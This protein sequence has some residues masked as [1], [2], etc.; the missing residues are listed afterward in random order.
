MNQ[1]NILKTG[2]GTGV[3][4]ALAAL[5]SVQLAGQA[6]ASCSFFGTSCSDL[7]VQSITPSVTNPVVGQPIFM[8]VIVRNQG[9][10]SASAFRVDAYYHSTSAPTTPCSGWNGRWSVGGLASGA[11]VTL[12]L[13]MS[14]STP[15]TKRFWVWA[16][17]CNDDSESN[18]SNNQRSVDITVTSPDL[19]VQSL[20]P[21]PSSPVAGQSITMTA[22]LR[23][24]GSASSGSSFLEVFH[25][26]PSAPTTS[27]VANQSV[28]IPGIAPGAT[29]TRTFTVSYPT[30]GTKH[31]WGYVDRS[32]SVRESSETNNSRV[33]AITVVEAPEPD[34]MVERIT[35]SMGNPRIGQAIDA[36]VVIKNQGTVATSLFNVGLF[37][38]RSSE[39][40]TICDADASG[41]SVGLAP[42]ETSTLTF[43]NITYASSGTKK[44]WVWVDYCN[45]VAE[46]DNSNN[47]SSETIEVQPEEDS[48]PDDPLKTNPGVCG[49]GV[50]DTDA[51]RNGVIDCLET[52][53]PDTLDSDLDGIADGL[54]N[55]PTTFNPDQADAD[56]DGTGDACEGPCIPM[57][58][59]ICGPCSAVSMVGLVGAMLSLRGN[60]GRRSS[61]IRGI[62]GRRTC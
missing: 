4:L 6:R 30:T 5:S 42:G 26:L 29:V 21:N 22:V 52:P 62:V 7:V 41:I 51:N 23:N 28:A 45:L 20:T 16:D 27:D 39:P 46:S 3:Y 60:R 56:S 37:F 18:G 40:I 49:C 55:C 44:L 14:Y 58:C 19:Y 53:G 11:T 59:G 50:P 9:S 57:F 10:Y 17:S 12:T 15:G 13:S 31:F 38:D 35:P 2:F 34:L 33:Y 43:R 61:R 47:Q 1:S 48:C 24:Q 8:T 32:N 36:D 54:D 25:D